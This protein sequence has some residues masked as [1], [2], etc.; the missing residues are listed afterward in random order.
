MTTHPV[1]LNCL[2]SKASILEAQTLQGLSS[3]DKKDNHMGPLE[4]A[5]SLRQPSVDHS[6]ITQ[7]P[8]CN[9]RLL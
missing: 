2:I 8:P 3:L 1:L 5:A 9:Y 7:N 4:K 6:P